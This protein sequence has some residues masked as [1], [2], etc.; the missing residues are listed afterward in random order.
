MSEHTDTRA[1]SDSAEVAFRK[2]FIGGLSFSTDEDK[3]RKYFKQYGNVQEAVVMKDPATKRSRGFGFVTF[4][5]VSSVDSA[6]ADEP[7]TIDGRKVCE[8]F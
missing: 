5:D 6:L 3:L 7:H 4:H 2:I 8:C 1:R